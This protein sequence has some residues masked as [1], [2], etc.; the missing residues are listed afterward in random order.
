VR[1]Y[2]DG[3]RRR[4]K[5][6]LRGRPF[7]VC[8]GTGGNIEELG[9]LRGPLCGKRG[10][11]EVQSKEVERIVDKLTRLT[12]AERIGELGLRPDRAD[13]IVP[14]A[15][16]VREVLKHAGLK[17]MLIPRVGLKNGILWELAAQTKGRAPAGE[18]RK[19]RMYAVEVG[20]R[21]NFDEAHAEAVARWALKLFDDLSH[22]HRLPVELAGVFE[23]SALL[24]D[25]GHVVNVN[26]H[27]K[28][29]CYLIQSS[30]LLGLTDRER[31]LAACIARYHRKSFPK[32]EHPEFAV[33]S[34]E[35][36]GIVTKL[37]A[38]IR[39]A[40]ACDCGHSRAV[41]SVR[42]KVRGRSLELC[43]RGDGDL[44]LERWALS[45]KADLFEHAYG[46][47]VS[48]R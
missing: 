47:N 42:T 6:E 46:M 17:K 31:R 37:A 41:R 1:G 18:R 28:H 27:H 23:I 14:A 5:R 26:G 4:L 16:M 45:R 7:D 43:L 39:L 20:R 19:A 34:P 25:I 44:L 36:R 9:D 24:H 38:I 30:P 33:L 32:L 35:D 22:V 29:S 21:F 40:D 12:L 13:V 8:I 3:L 15:I 11:A 10:N 2:V 48:V